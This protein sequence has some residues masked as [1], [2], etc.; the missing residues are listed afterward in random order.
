MTGGKGQTALVPWLTRSPR[1]TRVSQVSAVLKNPSLGGK[2][3]AALLGMR[4]LY[5]FVPHSSSGLGAVGVAAFLIGAVVM[6]DALQ[7]V[8]ILSGPDFLK[9][10]IANV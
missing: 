3:L 9:Q 1:R 5:G 2:P 10:L 8:E 7:I 6:N 4:G